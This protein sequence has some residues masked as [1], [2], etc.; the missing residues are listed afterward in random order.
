MEPTGVFGKNGDY[1]EN[2][3]GEN[4][5]CMGS[6]LPTDNPTNP[7]HLRGPK[8]IQTPGGEAFSRRLTVWCDAVKRLGKVGLQL[9]L[10]FRWIRVLRCS[11][12]YDR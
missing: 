9:M 3:R 1:T 12:R 5:R 10:A 8:L 11:E 2:L 7:K 4:N 6:D